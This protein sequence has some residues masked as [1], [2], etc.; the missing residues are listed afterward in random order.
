EHDMLKKELIELKGNISQMKEHNSA[1]E[2]SLQ[3]YREELD[4]LKKRYDLVVFVF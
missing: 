1:L 3:K 4:I 2:V